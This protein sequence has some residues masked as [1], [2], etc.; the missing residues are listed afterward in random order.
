MANDAKVFG[1]GLSNTGSSSLF[2]ALEVLGYRTATFRHMNDFKIYDWM[3]G[4]FSRNYLTTFDAVTDLPMATY[5]RELD[6][7]FPGSK[8]ILTDRNVDDWLA[9]VERRFSR[10]RYP[11]SQF[12]RDVRLAQYGVITFN[13]ARFRRLYGEHIAAVQH[14][15]RD[16]PDDLLRMNPFS[17][18]EWDVVCK[19]LEKPVPDQPYPALRPKSGTKQGSGVVP[20]GIFSES[21]GRFVF[22]IPI[23]HPE[24]SHVSDYEAVE[25]C[26]HATLT[27]LGQQTYHNVSVVVVCHSAPEW[28][29]EFAPDV[30]FLTYGDHEIFAANRNHV[31]IDKGMKYILGSLFAIER[32]QAENIMPMDGDDFMNRNIAH[33]VSARSV[34]PP[35]RDGYIFNNGFHAYLEAKPNKIELQGVFQ[36]EGFDETCGSCRVFLAPALARHIK[37][38]DPEIFGLADKFP[39]DQV[40]EI[41]IE[42]LDRIG[43]ST[44]EI[45]DEPESLVRLLGRHVRQA[46]HFDLARLASPMP[47]KGCGH[48]NHSG[49]T[50]GEIHWYRIRSIGQGKKFLTNFGLADCDDVSAKPSL[51]TN[52]RGFYSKLILRPIY[53]RKRKRW[54]KEKKRKA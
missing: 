12:T 48:G 35:G 10:N 27:S 36:V 32:L 47:A 19:F 34:R 14:Y 21:I 54:A 6:A 24:R 1:I 5:F 46:P 15:F 18:D 28:A 39:T 22:V 37:A 53:R 52:F 33:F 30:H 3:C 17:G 13:E 2:S 41:P 45:R 23:V 40:A 31:Q 4:D 20:P 50:K 38:L 29:E 26:L 44:D 7:R 49:P 43:A 51:A 25:R 42:L 11:D 9:S 8:F 16:R